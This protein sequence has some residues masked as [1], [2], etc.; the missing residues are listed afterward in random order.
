MT[1]ILSESILT[2]VSYSSELDN[3]QTCYSEVFEATCSGT[4]DIVK[5]ML[6][7]VFQDPL[8][9]RSVGLHNTTSD[10]LCL[11]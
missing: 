7:K 1:D 4:K 9:L 10:L 2:C 11:V 5:K 6:Q 8:Y 3:L